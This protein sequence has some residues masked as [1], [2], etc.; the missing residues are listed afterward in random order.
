MAGYTSNWFITLSLSW[1]IVF[2]LLVLSKTILFAV[3]HIQL[4]LSRVLLGGGD[5]PVNIITWVCSHPHHP[6]HLAS[7]HLNYHHGHEWVHT[8][9]HGVASC[10]N[11]LWRIVGIFHKLTLGGS[12]EYGGGLPWCPHSAPPS[13]TRGR[14]QDHFDVSIILLT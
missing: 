8:L 10:W 5:V 13:H 6:W 9:A 11:W 2:L 1:F 7:D 3:L 4:L 14:T 12:D